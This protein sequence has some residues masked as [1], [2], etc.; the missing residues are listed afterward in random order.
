MLL[1][2][3][4][5]ERFCVRAHDEG[6]ADNLASFLYYVSLRVSGLD[7]MWLGMALFRYAEFFNDTPRLF[8]LGWPFSL[9]ICSE[10]ASVSVCR[11][12][13]ACT[14]CHSFVAL[15]FV[16]EIT[17]E[18]ARMLALLLEWSSHISRMPSIRDDHSCPL[19]NWHTLPQSRPKL[20]LIDV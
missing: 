2:I 7:G 1:F 17:I 16:R 14:M 4:E 20:R 13:F 6:G 18:S 9:I 19:F 5:G 15:R 3:R 8:L 12:V 11:I 10:N